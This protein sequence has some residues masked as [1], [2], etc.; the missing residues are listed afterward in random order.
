V[1]QLAEAVGDA[2]LPFRMAR[3]HLPP[4]RR[5][6]RWLYPRAHADLVEASARATGCDPEL[7]LAVMR[8]ES[9]FRPDAR[10]GAGAVGLV[11]LIPP[12]AERLAEVHGVS[13][14]A[15]RDLESPAVSLPLGAAYLALLAER[16][17]DPA[18]VLAAYNAGPPAAAR[19]ALGRA[20]LPLDEWVE[21]IPFRETRR[22]V[23]SV[24]ADAVVY[25][26]LWRGGSLSIDGA[27]E[28][29]APRAGV[30]F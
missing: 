23:R 14:A 20:G 18:V 30:A 28:I 10:S 2:E 29:P 27:R 5:A 19:W 11:Q 8:R 22:Y 16:F 6:L 21:S 24:S 4:S 9:A 13:P 12:T 25:A 17:R 15:V 1:A 26:A 7:Y 3:D